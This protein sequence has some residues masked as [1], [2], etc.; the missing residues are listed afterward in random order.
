MATYGTVSVAVTAYDTLRFRWEYAGKSVT[1]NNTKVNWTLSLIAGAYGHIDSS[2]AKPW[3]VTVDG[4]Q[5]SG[6]CSVAISDNAT[7]TLAS[8]STTIDHNDDGTKTFRFSFS[9][10]FGITFSST[11]VGTKSG[12]GT[13]TLPTIARA[14]QPS[15]ITYPDHTQD[16]GEFGD[17]ISIHMNRA[18]SDFTHT[19]RYAFGDVTGTCI[20]AETGEQATAVGTGFKW[21]VP[22]SLMDLLPSSTSG[23]GTIYVDT[24]NGSTLVGTKSCGFTATVPESVKPTCSFTLEDITGIDEIYGSPVKGLSKIQ[25][26]VTAKTAYSSPITSYA[27]TANGVKYATATATTGVLTTAGTSPVRAF[28]TDKRGRASDSIG[29]DMTVQDYSPPAIS[30]LSVH[31]C[32]E[33][34]TT[35]DRGEYVKVTFSAAISSM[36]SINTALY[37]L[38][39]KKSADSSYTII[40]FNELTNTYSVT[41]HSYIFAAD[42]GSSYDVTVTA[43]DRHDTATRS[44]SASTAFTLINYYE[45]G[46]ALRFGGVAE[47]EN[48]FQND[49]NFVQTGNRYCFSSPG[50]AGTAGYVHMAQLTHIAANADTPIT[51]VFSQRLQPAPMVVHV[52]FRTDSTTVDPDLKKITY[53]GT[54]YGAYLVRSEASVWDLYVKKVSAYDTITLQD[55]YSTATVDNRLKITFP[56]ALVDTVPT[57]LDGYYRATPLVAD[58][59]IDCIMPVGFILTMYSHADPNSMFPGTTWERIVN[60]FL[61]ACDEDGGIG[62]TGGEKTHTL[63]VNELPAHNHGGTYTNAGTAT[64][65]HSWLSSGGSS[66]AFESVSAGGGAAHNNM[67]PYIQVSVW[68]RTA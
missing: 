12:S 60:R 51:F 8:G 19:V 53:E 23:S 3:S 41:D 9:V 18:S 31:R 55:W 57:G 56:G 42:S 21:V 63:T 35:N 46:N 33:D 1:Y 17:T 32:D 39:Y 22:L 28:V 66:M 16:V 64:K 15:C 7:K 26:V 40:S 10:T 44:T 14:S 11:Y 24:Y 54:N 43:A 38:W 4:Q 30:A 52:Q 45:A 50:I 27:I 25:I 2:Q 62:T 48:T 61:W 67:P 20:D 5:Y 36:N 58:S 65:T 37:K 34:G 47:K 68:R 13:G 59:I 29:Y 49:L 6:T